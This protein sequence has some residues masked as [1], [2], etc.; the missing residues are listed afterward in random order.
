VISRLMAQERR[1]W[2]EPAR[3]AW[4][5][6]APRAGTWVR[7]APGTYVYLFVLLITT[8]VLQT[9]SSR[10]A[11]R[12]L[13]ERSTNLHQLS[14]DPVR[15]LFASGFWVSSGPEL[16][17]WIVLFCVV[18]APVTLGLG[19]DDALA[20]FDLGVYDAADLGNLR[21]GPRVVTE[22]PEGEIAALFP[23]EAEEFFQA[24][25]AVAHGALAL[26]DPGFRILVVERGA[27]ELS[28]QGGA[29]EVGGGETWVI[30]HGA[31]ALTLRGDA[32]AI[33]CAPPADE[34]ASA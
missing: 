28:W 2:L 18:V 6:V 21:P 34:R 12:L 16:V 17:G 7:S 1:P 31:G 33:L 3:K 27:A 26:G 15:V 32:Q 10:V 19:W 4:R 8:W 29:D 14:R 20:S 24:Y 9:S 25:R 23:P 30:P 5:W 13:L 11:N 22:S